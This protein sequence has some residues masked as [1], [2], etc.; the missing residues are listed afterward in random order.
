[1]VDFAPSVLLAKLR[2]WLQVSFFQSLKSSLVSDGKQNWNHLHEYLRGHENS[3]EKGLDAGN[4]IGQELRTCHYLGTEN[5]KLVY[6][7][8][9]M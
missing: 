7:A 1:M 5:W 9:I 2:L 6:I 8:Y 3:P 4:T